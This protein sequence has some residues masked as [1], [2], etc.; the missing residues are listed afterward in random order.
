MEYMTK[1]KPNALIIFENDEE[2]VNSGADN[3]AAEKDARGYGVRLA[4][5]LS[6]YFE[7]GEP[8]ANGSDIWE[9]LYSSFPAVI[10][11]S[12]TLRDMDPYALSRNLCAGSGAAD[13]MFFLCVKTVI[14]SSVLLN[15]KTNGIHSA[16]SAETDP[17]A[18]AEMIHDAWTEH[19]SDDKARLDS[20]RRFLDD[21][22]YFNESC[23]GELA[24]GIRERLLAP[25]GFDFKHKGT[26]YIQ[27]LIIFRILGMDCSYDKAYARIG[28]LYKTTGR[29]VERAIRYSIEYAWEHSK[30][31]V[32]QEFFGNTID[33][34]RGK[35]TN[36]E[37]IEM[38][39]I[40]IK[41]LYTANSD[42]FP[43]LG[44]K[45]PAYLAEE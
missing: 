19:I 17:K 4:E 8:I 22:L 31:Y 11:I 39:I 25:L 15:C 30:P 42:V 6:E 7:T 29:S 28:E 24:D 45:M 10:V 3:G 44:C 41:Y 36:S 2:T 18:V 9:R 1:Q 37:F 23:E 5:A 14:N 33:A 21:E 43:K 27:T 13:I 16:F 26:K 34:S 38:M 12:Q 35:P 40:N 20:I 32:Q